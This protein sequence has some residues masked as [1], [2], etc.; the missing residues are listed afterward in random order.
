MGILRLPVSLAHDIGAHSLEAGAVARQKVRIVQTAGHQRMDQRQQHRGVGARPDRNPFGVHGHRT[1]RAV[2]TD[3][4]DVDAGAR[5]F[6]KPVG[7]EVTGAAAL[8]HLHVLGLQ[9][10]NSTII[11]AWRAIDDHDVSGPVT[12]CA[13]P[14]TCGRNTSAVPKL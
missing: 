7:V 1:V 12:G 6:G 13:L 2:R 11:L 8:G 4:D 10:P 5:E 9:P 3:D 14:S